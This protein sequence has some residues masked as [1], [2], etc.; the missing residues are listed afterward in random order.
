MIY[1]RRPK[2]IS[3]IQI[4]IILTEDQTL[5]FGWG[6]TPRPHWSGGRMTTSDRVSLSLKLRKYAQ[7]P[8][9]IWKERKVKNNHHQLPS[10]DFLYL[11]QGSMNLPKLMTI[12]KLPQRFCRMLLACFCKVK[13]FTL[14]SE[15]GEKG[16]A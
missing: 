13:R 4:H 15:E 7:P 2:P 14:P 16:R 9:C 10:T 8:P 3:F 12:D 11:L 5:F 1:A 6:F